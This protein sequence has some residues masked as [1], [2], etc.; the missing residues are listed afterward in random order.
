MVLLVSLILL[1][2][3][4]ILAI[5]AASTSTLQQRMASNAQEQNTSFQAAE[6]GLARWQI[7]FNANDPIPNDCQAAGANA[8]YCLT[9]QIQANCL[10][11]SIGVGSGFV[12]DC[13]HITSNART[14]T[15]ARS[16]HQMGYL[17]RLGQ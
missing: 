4:T 5:T 16:R 11:G 1:L 6:S 3:L 13:Y 14:D 17:T 7:L 2:I 12:F 10:A 15:D 9:Q 8:E